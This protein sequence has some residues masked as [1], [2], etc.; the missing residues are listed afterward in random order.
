MAGKRG[1][2]GQKIMLDKKIKLWPRKYISTKQKN[3]ILI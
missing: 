2:K 3:I 1:N